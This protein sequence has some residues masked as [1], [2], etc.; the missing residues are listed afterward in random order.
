MRPETT[1]QAIENALEKAR[2]VEI[3][4]ADVCLELARLYY[5]A[6]D[7]QQAFRWCVR[8]V[9]A[10]LD[11][12][13][14]DAASRVLKRVLNSYRPDTHRAVKL[15][16]LGSYTTDQLVDLVRLVAARRG[17]SVELYQ[18]GFGL[19]QQEVLDNESGLYAFGPDLVLLALHEGQ[20]MLP[21]FSDDPEGEVEA[22][23]A[24]WT[25]FWGRIRSGPGGKVIQTNFVSRP[26]DPFGH[27]SARLPGTRRSMM[28]RLNMRL[29]EE[30][31][32]EV[33][34]LDCEYLASV[35][36]R[37]TWFDDRYWYRSKQAVGFDALPSMARSL[38]ALIS[39]ELGLSRKCLVLDLDGTL[40]GG[41]V[42][43]VG[44]QGIK[45]GHGPDGEAFAAF[46]EYI[47]SL[48]DRGIVLAVS[49]KNDEATAKEP[50]Q[51]HPDMRLTI[52]DFAM[53]IANW[54]PKPDNLK[55]I[56]RGLD[57]GT[58]ALVFVDDG[59]NE[60]EAVRQALPEVDVLVI[61][62][63]PAHYIHALAA[64]PYFETSSFTT[65]DARRAEQYRTRAQAAE[66]EAQ[67]STLEDFWEDLEMRATIGEIDEFRM[68]RV[69]QLIGKTNQFN[70]TAKRYGWDDVESLVAD[71]NNIHFYVE[72]SDRLGDHG[73][74]AVVICRRIG[75]RMEIDTL[76]MSCRVIGRSLEAMILSEVT[77]R[78]R[79]KGCTKV[80]G[81]YRKT[82]KNGL[83]ADL[84][85]RF[86][87]EQEAEDAEGSTWIYDLARGPISNP[88]I[89]VDGR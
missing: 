87:F 89:A 75:D 51:H 39:A 15:A 85:P 4:S 25:S 58:D 18:A 72:L 12:R 36:G 79:D 37:K 46:Q 86:G 34:I 78:A 11:Y 49:S 61:P 69:V 16:V 66:L 74:V 33:V 23:V 82:A 2:S 56:A 43:E 62:E 68:P 73:L 1:T 22:E 24:R 32:N 14:W 77:S 26:E 47:L 42:G 31:G 48:K 29:G 30:A 83:V 3:P 7:Y 21:G 70:L 64:Y 28:T 5:E 54:E 10:G 71:D 80:Q 84:Y 52:D 17:I 8:V 53:F 35:C 67:A 19:Y 76:L 81:V 45:I 60:R 27:I 55:R 63:D 65:D 6:D 20:V 13:S 88:Y 41:V 50:F 40:W 44:Y 57:L 59:P 38:V 9:D